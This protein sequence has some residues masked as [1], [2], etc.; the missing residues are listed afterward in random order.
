MILA[1]D[2]DGVICREGFPVYGARYWLFRLRQLG[3]KVILFSSGP[4]PHTEALDYCHMEGIGHD[5]PTEPPTH[6]IDNRPFNW[7]R[8]HSPNRDIIP[9]IDWIKLGP[10]LLKKLR[11]T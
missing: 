7:P 1:V 9:Y 3:A 10:H 8:V 6:Y 11:E 5:D 2:F 4:T